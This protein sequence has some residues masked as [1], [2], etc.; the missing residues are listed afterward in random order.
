MAHLAVSL[1]WEYKTK[2]E[3]C[4]GLREG[5]WLTEEHS[6]CLAPQVSVV[7]KGEIDFSFALTHIQG[8]YH[9]DNK[10]SKTTCVDT[11]P[12]A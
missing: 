7:R 12:A 4:W 5:N 1:N 11:K 2:K 8:I 3:P 9:I 6:R 10:I